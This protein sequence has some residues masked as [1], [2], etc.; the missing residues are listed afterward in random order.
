[1]P[2]HRH[3]RCGGVLGEHNRITCRTNQ[4][5]ISRIIFY[6]KYLKS[7]HPTPRSPKGTLT[8]ERVD[9]TGNIMAK[10]TSIP[11]DYRR[12]VEAPVPFRRLQF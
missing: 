3:G 5:G 1:M 4:Q 11:G 10:V 2:V 9:S 8:T 6:Q 7:L 12:E